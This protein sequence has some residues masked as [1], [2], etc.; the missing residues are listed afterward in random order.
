MYTIIQSRQLVCSLHVFKRAVEWL[1]Y[2]SHVVALI[3]S[4]IKPCR[5][6]Q[7]DSRGTWRMGPLSRTW[8]ISHGAAAPLRHTKR[9]IGAVALMVCHVE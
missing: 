2:S 4:G 7:Q 5:A 8:N 9:Y 1:L 3:E 6:R